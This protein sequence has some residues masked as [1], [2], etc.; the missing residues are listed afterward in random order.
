[1]A[2]VFCMSSA[3][4]ITTTAVMTGNRQHIPNAAKEQLVTVSHH[5]K[6]KEIAQVVGTVNRVPRPANETGSV[7]RE[8]LS[9]WPMAP[10]P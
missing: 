4:H 6:P 2:C 3:T 9:K 7:V 10:F 8:A 5:T 1:M